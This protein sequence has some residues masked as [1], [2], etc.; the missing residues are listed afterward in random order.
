MFVI[1]LAIQE[2]G[3]ASRGIIQS[4]PHDASAILVYVLMGMFVG[5]IIKGSKKRQS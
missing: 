1:A 2:S 5:L 4:I 3:S